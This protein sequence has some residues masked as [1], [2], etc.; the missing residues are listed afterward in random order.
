M[1][2]SELITRVSA[3]NP[4]LFRADV[5]KIVDI[6]LDGIEAAI[7]RGDRVEL[8]GFGTFSARQRSARTGR[9]P[10]TGVDVAVNQKNSPYFKGGKEMHI[11]LNKPQLAQE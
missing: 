7:T 10:R 8:R 6:I 4:H 1:I 3:Q 11:R 9:N 2:K 5:A